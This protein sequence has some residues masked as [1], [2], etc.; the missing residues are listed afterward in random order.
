[1]VNSEVIPFCVFDDLWML[2][3]NAQSYKP[4]ASHKM[5]KNLARTE[6]NYEIYNR[7]SSEPSKID[8]N[9]ASA[10]VRS[11]Q[12]A[13]ARRNSHPRSYQATV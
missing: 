5:P 2:I 4:I 3:A 7:S 10:E 1:M 11:V 9:S 12:Q 6:Y 13:E 8:G